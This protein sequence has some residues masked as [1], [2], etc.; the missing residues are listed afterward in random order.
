MN[1]A[2]ELLSFIK[3]GTSPFHVAA[4]SAK[5]L[6]A[7]GFQSLDLCRDWNLQ[8]GGRYY[9]TVY[10]TSLFAFHIGEKLETSHS[11]RILSAHTDHPCLR[12]KPAPEMT[13]KSFLKVN[14]ECYGGLIRNTWMDR[15][16]SVAGRVT[17]KGDSVF[18][19]RTRLVEISRPLLTIPNLA[20][21]VNREINSGQELN[22]QNDMLPIAGLLEDDL[23]QDTFFY[24]FL[25]DE[26]GVPPEDILD[27]D[28]YVYNAEDGCLLG[29][30]NE[31]LS[32][33]RLDN[34][35]SVMACLKG[36]TAAG[37]GDVNGK[38]V[39]L[40]ALY[41]NEEVGSQ[42]KQG[43]DSMITTILLKKLYAALGISEA[44]MYDN[45]LAGLMI[46]MDVAHGYHPNRPDKNDLTNFPQAGGGFALKINTS[47]RYATDSAALGVIQQLCAAHRIPY[48]KYVNRS[49]IPGGSTLGSLSSAWLPMLTAD[50]GVPVL[51]MHSA[52]E[53]MAA[54]DQDSLNRLAM[55]FFMEE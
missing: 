4:E 6:D 26:L 48:Q 10:G 30:R 20:I 41:D 55:E 19:P 54:G 16:L 15:P 39:S 1:A 18:A 8:R 22:P 33:P 44:R 42:T 28:L 21:H 45:L 2:N 24:D 51:A 29:L 50:V 5:I 47:Q 34:L 46:S 35:T 7:A 32:A 27:F 49:D 11:L 52:R 12:I 9:V 14:V 43:A 40:I 25:A 36:I 31:F 38:S 13:S 17:L 3:K 23:N 37:N 53:L